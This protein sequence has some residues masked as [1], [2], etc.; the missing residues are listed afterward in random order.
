M[1]IIYISSENHEHDVEDFQIQAHKGNDP[2]VKA[3]AAKTL[4]TLQKHLQ[5]IRDIKSK[6]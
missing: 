4:P 5:M 1:A 3:F 2:D 6:M